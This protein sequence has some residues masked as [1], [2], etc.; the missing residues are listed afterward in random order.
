MTLT[1]P[2][3]S[4]IERERAIEFL[5]AGL[6]AREGAHS[7]NCHNSMIV[8]LQQHLWHPATTR[9]RAWHGP[10]RVTTRHQ[11]RLIYLYHLHNWPERYHQPTVHTTPT[12]GAGLATKKTHVGPIVT[13]RHLK[14]RIQW[15]RTHRRWTQRHWGQIRFTDESTFHQLWRLAGAGVAVTFF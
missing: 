8:T 14:Q 4:G 6:S 12:T 7:F 9:H 2:R 3:R 13:Q 11:D 15:A 10:R 1:M 5:R